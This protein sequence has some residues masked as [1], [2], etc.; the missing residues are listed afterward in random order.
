[1]HFCRLHKLHQDPVLTLNGSPIPVAEETKFLGVYCTDTV[2][3]VTASTVILRSHLI[4]RYVQNCTTVSWCIQTA[5][6]EK[7]IKDRN[8]TINNVILHLFVQRRSYTVITVS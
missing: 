7:Q 2:D 3:S 4:Y 8:L 1:M 5:K 6:N